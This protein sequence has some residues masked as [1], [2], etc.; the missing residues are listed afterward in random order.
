MKSERIVELIAR[1]TG[2]A[3][4]AEELAELEM[5]LTENPEYRFM[6]EVFNSIESSPQLTSLRP[7][8]QEIMN[9][10][11]QQLELRLH[12]IQE[13]PVN[14]KKYLWAAAVALLL[15]TAGGTWLWRSGGTKPMVAAAT[16]SIHS[17]LGH[18][19][20][21]VLPDGT[22]VWLN[23]GSRLTYSDRFSDS[24]RDVTVTGEVFFDVVKD[25]TKP[26]VVHTND[27][28]IQVLGTSFNVKAYGDDRKAE[29]T[30]IGGKVQVVMSKS[31][32]KK[33][34][35]LPHEKLVLSLEKVNITQPTTAIQHATFQVQGLTDS[36]DSSLVVETAWRDQ[37]LA[38]M[39]ET[40]IEV[41]K[42]MERL[43]DVKIHF[44]DEA[45]QQEVLSG[46]FEKEDIDKALQLLQMTTGFHY[47]MTATDIYLS[48]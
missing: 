6:E 1:K 34:V 14:K 42:K 8:E 7:T 23:A 5:L 9:S 31:P 28:S 38:F 29:V 39:N 35:L 2:Q 37:K 11:W 33:V 22:K 24:A 40:F 32:E 25:D 44:E 46:V 15:A 30:V 17:P 48:K 20:H 13:A 10:G 16:H 45:L 19:I 41:A 26:F 18:T 4:S 3:A 21:T 43:Y 12:T 36:K 27:L 47:S